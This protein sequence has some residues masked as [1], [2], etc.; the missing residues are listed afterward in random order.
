MTQPLRLGVDFTQHI[1]TLFETARFFQCDIRHTANDGHR[2][3]QFMGGIRDK[4][5]LLCKRLV[6]APDH[7]IKGQSEVVYFVPGP[8]NRD[9]LM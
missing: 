3:A 8:G 5:A 4:A 6:Q 2:C 1:D 7:L 9:S